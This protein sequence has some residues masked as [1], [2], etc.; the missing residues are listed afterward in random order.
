VGGGEELKEAEN[1]KRLFTEP[2][3][4]LRRFNRKLSVDRGCVSVV[5]KKK[6]K[7]ILAGSRYLEKQDQR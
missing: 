1:V 6:R 3:F 5:I 2:F 7:K 4:L